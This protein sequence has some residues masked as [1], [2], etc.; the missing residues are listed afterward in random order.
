MSVCLG[1][2]RSVYACVSLCAQ[3]DRP[4][5]DCG[6]AT[7]WGGKWTTGRGRM[8]GVK[9]VWHT[10]PTLPHMLS[11]N[12]AVE[13]DNE[14]SMPEQLLACSTQWWRHTSND[15]LKMIPIQRSVF[16]AVPLAMQAYLYVVYGQRW[17]DNSLYC[18]TIW[19]E[20]SARAD[21]CETVW[22]RHYTRGFS[23]DMT[24]ITQVAVAGA[25]WRWWVP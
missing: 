24:T 8:R 23:V 9:H 16:D 14:W 13:V 2:C 4:P 17:I 3:T 5:T 1:V 19:T 11:V 7:S 20:S 6:N 22:V 18:A 25:R 15:W 12:R 21:R 10:W